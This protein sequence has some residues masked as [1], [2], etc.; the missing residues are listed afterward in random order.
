MDDKY[1]RGLDKLTQILGIE[2]ATR[3][4]TDFDEIN[5]DIGKY[6]AKFVYG[7]LYQSDVLDLK[8]RQLCTI[9]ALT[10]LGQYKPHLKTHIVGALN[11]GASKSEI[12][13]VIL[14]ML[15]Y[16]G[17]PAATTALAVARDIFVE[18]NH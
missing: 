14:Q 3:A 1:L 15:A 18:G 11:V 8:T 17:F 13:E 9:A 12:I 4:L 7:E 5:P 10:V 16:A 6:I 2:S